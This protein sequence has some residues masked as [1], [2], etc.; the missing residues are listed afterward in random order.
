MSRRTQKIENYLANEKFGLVFSNMEPGHIFEGIVGNDFG[1]ML[2]VNRPQKPEFAYDFVRIHSLMIYRELIENK[3][4]GDT[5][6]LLLRCLLYFFT[7]QAWRHDNY[8]RVYEL[9]DL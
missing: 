6:A 5:K 8:W 3:T 7:T 9:S 4:V 1:V 2:K